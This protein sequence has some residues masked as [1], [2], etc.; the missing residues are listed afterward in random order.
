MATADQA[1]GVLNVGFTRG[2]SWGLLLDFDEPANLTG[3][4]LYATLHSTVTGASVQAVT[5]TPVDL[6]I[7]K[8]NLSLTSTQTAALAAGTYEFRVGWSA[9][10][11]RLVYQGFAQVRA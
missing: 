9:P 10:S 4:T 8:V 1:P 7:G 3:Y 11:Q 2:E 6:T 5:V